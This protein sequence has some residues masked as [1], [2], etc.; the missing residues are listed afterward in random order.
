MKKSSSPFRTDQQ[1]PPATCPYCGKVLAQRPKRKKKCPACKNPIYVRTD[2]ETG[3]K[4]LTTEESAQVMDWLELLEH[5]GITKRDFLSQK[6]RLSKKFGTKAADRDVISS[7]FN[8]LII[9]HARAADFRTAA[10]IYRNMATFKEEEGKNPFQLLQQAS[11]MELMDYKQS[12]CT[13]VEITTCN[14]NYVCP[15]CRKLAGKVFDINDALEALPIPNRECTTDLEYRS[16]GYC[17]CSYIGL[18]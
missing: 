2:P 3:E 15:S 1:E 17:R 7:L 12:G 6:R 9:R 14:D 4:I 11:R 16:H 10:L 13:K 5:Y 8:D 18:L